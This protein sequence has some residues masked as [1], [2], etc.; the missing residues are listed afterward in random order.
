MYISKEIIAS[1]SMV[2]P[3]PDLKY[4]LKKQIEASKIQ[5]FFHFKVI[6]GKDLR[7]IE[8]PKKCKIFSVLEY[9]GNDTGHKTSFVEN[10]HTPVFEDNLMTFPIDIENQIFLKNFKVLLK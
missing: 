6:F 10:T 4:D 3:P 7:G 1:G 9:D 8:D 5:G 2:K